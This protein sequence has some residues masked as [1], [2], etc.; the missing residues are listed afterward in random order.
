MLFPILALAFAVLAI[1]DV[2][3]TYMGLKVPGAFETNPFGADPLVLWAVKVA[4]MALMF[5]LL[6]GHATGWAD[7]LRWAI[8]AFLF[9]R[10]VYAVVNNVQVIRKG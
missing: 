8:I 1:L 6:L 5:Y 2:A 3:T 10:G 9:A 4:G 7:V